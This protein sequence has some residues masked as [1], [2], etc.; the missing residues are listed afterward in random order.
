[1]Y[2]NGTTNGKRKFL[3][4]DDP[5]I[6]NE[7][8]HS[9]DAARRQK[10]SETV[11]NV[12]F[13]Y[14]SRKVWSWRTNNTHATL[15]PKFALGIISYK[16]FRRILGANGSDTSHFSI[17]SSIQRSRIWRLSMVNQLVGLSDTQLNTIMHRITGC[18]RPTST[19]KVST[20]KHI[21][22]LKRECPTAWI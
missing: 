19:Y 3:D 14:S 22:P 13:K 10:W 11:E 6:A 20:M 5:E 2:P 12:E 21:H 8:L 1:M 7:L 16:N 18:I 17:R 9:L 15:L 4:D